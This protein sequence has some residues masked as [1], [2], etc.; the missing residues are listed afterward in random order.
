[1]KNLKISPKLTV[2]FSTVNTFFICCI[3]ALIVCYNISHGRLIT[4]HDTVLIAWEHIADVRHSL[5]QEH[6]AAYETLPLSPDA[7]AYA[8]AT[9]A[10]KAAGSQTLA[11]IDAL[12]VSL[13]DAAAKNLVSALRSEYVESYAKALAAFPSAFT[14][15]N[16]AQVDALL[17]EASRA[18]SALDQ[19]IDAVSALVSQQ[20][21]FLLEE[22]NSGQTKV[23]FISAIVVSFVMI[24]VYFII[25]YL[26]RTIAWPIMA[27]AS[28][29][30]RLVEGD[31]TTVVQRSKYT[32]E[33]AILCNAF[34]QVAE[35]MQQQSSLL[36]TVA[37]GDLT[38]SYQKRSEQDV[39]GTAINRMLQN[40]TELLSEVWQS[41]A[42]VAG[43][44]QQIAHGAQNLA[45]TSTEQAA[46][47][48]ELSMAIAGVQDQ[49]RVSSNI[50][51]QVLS[52]I[53][54]S[55]RM[56]DE[57][58][59]NMNRMTA[60][61]Q[62]IS[63]SSRD[64]AKVIKVIDDIA[65]QTNILALNAAVEAARAGQHG[66]GFAVVA[67]E[68]RD[69]ASKSAAAAKDTAALIESSLQNVDKGSNVAR[70]TSESLL[71]VIDIAR[72]IFEG[73]ERQSEA[74]QQQNASI[75]EIHSGIDQLS[76]IIQQNSATSQENA[77]AAQEMDAL[78]S[79]LKTTVERFRLSDGGLQ[80]RRAMPG[81]S[82]HA[83]LDANGMPEAPID[84]VHF[85]KY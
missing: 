45:Q 17:A 29:A 59:D 7:P 69:L 74:S 32:D 19:R 63:E 9:G 11:V 27:V 37:Q 33:V 39:M 82:P 21:A 43:A 31:L 50:A 18:A 34:V 62:A 49:A 41:S 4:M 68:V 72:S 36:V 84:D 3:I 15:E 2:S 12:M 46:T 58:N 48:E 67:D 64:I 81:R 42:Q 16:I 83:A 54:Q 13:D 1:M 44:S 47:V 70:H 80:E 51:A 10:L 35:T 60:T 24:L 38:A 23:Y 53:Q 71:R 6:M 66:K 77:A 25:V 22:A 61:M 75:G 78:A 28:N 65:F 76:I 52:D 73:M 20:D 40:L 5:H 30:K 55:S 26:K 56:M 8:Q 14:G 79:L 85:G 57:S